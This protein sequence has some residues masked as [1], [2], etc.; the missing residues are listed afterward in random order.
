MCISMTRRWRWAWWRGPWWRWRARRRSRR[1]WQSLVSKYFETESVAPW[2]C[3]GRFCPLQEFSAV[4][5]RQSFVVAALTFAGSARPIQGK[6]RQWKIA[7]RGLDIAN[8]I[9]CWSVEANLCNIPRQVAVSGVRQRE[10][11]GTAAC[12][13]D[14]PRSVFAGVFHET[15][16]P[17][18]CLKQQARKIRC[19]SVYGVY[20]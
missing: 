7:G 5:L 12:G 10:H 13:G 8:G 9:S 15:F 3:P 18:T 11:K 20:G 16:R 14:A 19:R 2:F 1:P 6:G 17:V 4:S